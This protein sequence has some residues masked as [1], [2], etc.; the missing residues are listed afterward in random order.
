M[1]GVPKPDLP[2]EH[3]SRSDRGNSGEGGDIG[4]SGEIP[5]T[6]TIPAAVWPRL[7]LGLSGGAVLLLAT[8]A[9]LFALS[10]ASSVVVPM[11]LGLTFSYALTPIVNWLV[12]WNVPRA[13]AAALLLGSIV[14]GITSVAWSLSDEAASMLETLPDVA[15]KIRR[16][17]AQ[18]RDG[19]AVAAI[20]Q[21]QKAAAEIES[22]AANPVQSNSPGRVTRVQIEPARFDIRDYLWTGTLGLL[23]GLGYASVILFVSFFLLAAGDTFRRK[24]AKIAGPN[25]GTRRLAVTALDEINHHI[26]RYLLVQL[27]TSVIVGL[28][29]WLSFWWLGV[30][31][32]AVWG[33]LGFVLNLIPYFGNVV[34]TGAAALYAFVQ[35]GSVR[36]ALAVGG[37]ALLINVLE[38]NLLTPWLTVRASRLNPVAVFVGVLAWGWL[39]GLGGLFLGMPILIAIKAICDRVE[40]LQPVGEILGN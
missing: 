38:S 13:L 20:T 16:E 33:V 34:L 28:A 39:W 26:Q 8:L 24:L 17:L 5:E 23:S 2:L 22:A 19:G 18:S 6:T 4:T 31:N 37:V 9:S 35:F 1:T 25:F 32:A 29:V 27:F 14:G 7:G 15:Q 11:L 12:R 3:Q 21:V 30:D 36:M 10:W 40:E